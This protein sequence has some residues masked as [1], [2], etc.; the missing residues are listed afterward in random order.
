[1]QSPYYYVNIISEVPRSAAAVAAVTAAE[2]E[3]EET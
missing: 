2:K 3:L 1:M